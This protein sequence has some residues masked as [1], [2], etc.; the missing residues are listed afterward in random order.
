MRCPLCDAD[1]YR[2]RYDST[3]TEPIDPQRHYTSTSREFGR[4]GRI[5]ECR[6]CGI[7]YMNPRP[8]H[9]AVQDAY[10]DVE[11]VRY[12]EE[13]EG[14]VADLLREPRPH[15][16]LRAGRAAA[17]RRLPRRHVHRA[18][19]AARAS[20]SRGSSRRAG[21]PSAPRSACAGRC[22]SASSRTR[23]CPRAPTTSSRCGTSSSICPIPASTLRAVHSALR[24]GGV[25]AVTTM[26][27]DALFP[28]VAGAL[29]ALVHADAP[30]VLLPP[31]ARRAAAP[32]R[33]RGRRGHAPPPH[34][35]RL[36][37]R[38]PPGHLQPHRGARRARA[39][40]AR[41]PS[42]RSASTSGTS[43]PWWRASPRTDAPPAAATLERLSTRLAPAR[44]L[45]RACRYP[46]LVVALSRL[47]VVLLFAMEGWVT[48]PHGQG[49]GLPQ[50]LRDLGAWDGI[51]YRSIAVHGYDPTIG[52]GDNA[53][54]LPLYPMVLR[55]LRTL[56]PFV[57]L[58]W[59]GAAASTALMAVGMCLLYKL[60][61]ERFGRTIAR[62]TVLFL[63]ISP[64]AFVFSAVYAESLFLVL[65][66]GT[67]LLAERKRFFW[68]SV[69]G[70][71]GVLTR[72]VGLALAPALIWMAWGEREG[73]WRRVAAGR[74]A[75][76]GRG[77]L[78][79]LPVVG[80]GRSP[81]ADPCAGARLGTQPGPAAA[82][83]LERLH[84]ARARSPRAPVSRP[85]LLRDRLDG[86]ARRS[87]GSAATRC[88]SPTSSS[89]PAAS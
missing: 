80:D 5:V 24:P 41:S 82:R 67:F 42:A 30:R 23:R 19:R 17:R 27:V 10:G 62:R 22:A 75:A 44:R 40:A 20:T 59:L 61:D 8:H 48:R 84:R 63:S 3:L 85:H 54:F 21:R 43:S 26:D 58:V 83:H 66:T 18:G 70:A 89:P 50:M 87:S 34:R 4:F 31:H 78:H 79:G 47:V 32:L 25:F 6:S 64:L 35:A 39:H 7:V 1:H 12:V 53:A 88:R 49:V 68:A 55:G 13:E 51:W 9:L 77:A 28:R 72:P 52:H 2:V 37:R 46:L 73:R 76:G 60:T 71:L 74:A 57:D 33:L 36:L 56:A 65:A 81:R 69:L 15:P 16:R 29:L 86:H 11:D 14:R 38:L 45:W